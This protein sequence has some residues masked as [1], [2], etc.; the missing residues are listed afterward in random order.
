MA[1]SSKDFFFKR[2]RR[3][4]PCIK[5][6]PS[7]LDT[8]TQDMYID[9][10]INLI[11]ALNLYFD[12][13]ITNFKICINYFMKK[14]IGYSTCQRNSVLIIRLG[15]LW[16]CAVHIMKQL[17]SE[18][19]RDTPTAVRHLQTFICISYELHISLYVLEIIMLSVR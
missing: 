4:L 7:T 10:K 8:T 11:V 16:S 3:L 1:F 15:W 17:I 5:P 18:T 6:Y 13:M 2:L 19:T 14:K 12:I 9:F